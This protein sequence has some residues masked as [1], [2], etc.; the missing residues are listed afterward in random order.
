[1]WSTN[2]SI[3]IYID[4]LHVQSSLLLGMTYLKTRKEN[5]SMID[6]LL[7]TFFLFPLSLTDKYSRAPLL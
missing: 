3:I 1:M 2:I 4:H 7:N 6:D 5:T